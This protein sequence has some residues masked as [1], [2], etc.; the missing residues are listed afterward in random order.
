M[1][2]G[3][4]TTTAHESSRRPSYHKPLIEPIQKRIA[5][6]EDCPEVLEIVLKALAEKIPDLEF[7]HTHF[8]TSVDQSMNIFM[9]QRPHIVITDLCLSPGRYDGFEILARIR[10]IEP[11]TRVALSS[12]IYSAGAANDPNPNA[13]RINRKA[14]KKDFDALFHK[15]DLEGLSA[16]V[17]AHL[18][19]PF[20]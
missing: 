1:P 10:R 11:E 14:M 13:R 2:Y 6:F 12:S 9:N 4:R 19:E 8:V 3:L 15:A 20:H 7:T 16:F 5:V 18:D 17:R